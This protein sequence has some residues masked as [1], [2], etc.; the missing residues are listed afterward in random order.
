MLP[1][2]FRSTE[3]RL[4]VSKTDNRFVAKLSITENGFH[5]SL[6]RKEEMA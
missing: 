2:V 5:I 4:T 1:K 6:I 3:V